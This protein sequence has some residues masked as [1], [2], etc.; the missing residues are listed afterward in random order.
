MRPSY[1]QN[2][3]TMKNTVTLFLFITCLFTGSVYGQNNSFEG[4]L[5]Y[6]SLS[7]YDTLSYTI[8]VKNDKIRLEEFSAQGELKQIF[9]F[10]RKQG[11]SL[12]LSPG[13]KKF[14]TLSFDEQM[15]KESKDEYEV[16]KTAN[17]KVIDGK[18]CYQWRIKNPAKRAEVTYWVAK[19][20]YDFFQDL[21]VLLTFKDNCW[22]FYCHI[23]NTDGYMPVVMTERNLVRTEK[24][25]YTLQQID[26]KLIKDE[27]F[28]IPSDYQ[29]LR[30]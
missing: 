27:L 25:R 8:Y 21:S 28:Q 14:M 10:D 22:A 4:A 18:T 24:R 26:L 16:L 9:L 20:E 11:S 3:Y 6:T 2:Y 5:H 17:Y 7:K 29:P 1:F 23:P 19:G 30:L 12:L 13:E 15:V